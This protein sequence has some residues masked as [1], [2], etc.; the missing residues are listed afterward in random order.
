MIERFNAEE[1]ANQVVHQAENTHLAGLWDAFA[2]VY[3][4][5]SH[6]KSDADYEWEEDLLDE[7]EREEI[8]IGIL[9][10][11]DDSN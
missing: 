1:A 5:P 8:R 4:I 10:P 6:N 11:K 7:I 2:Y 3:Q 9:P